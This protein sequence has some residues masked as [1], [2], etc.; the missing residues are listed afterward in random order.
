MKRRILLLIGL[1]LPV[2]ALKAQTLD[3][4][5]GYTARPL[6]TVGGEV[7]L[8]TL[9]TDVAGNIYYLSHG[10][11]GGALDTQLLRRNRDAGG[12]YSSETLIFSYG[13]NQSLFG[14][15][16]KVDNANS[17]IYFADSSP[18]ASNIRAIGTDLSNPRIITAL[19]GT[20]DIALSPLGL[21]VSA[22]NAG[23][24][25]AAN[26]VYKLNVG[27]GALDLIVDVAGDYSG[28]IEL[29]LAGNLIYG[30]TAF[31]SI[32]G[33]LYTFS[34]VQIAGAIGASSLTL[35]DGGVLADTQSNNYL[36]FRDPASL[37][38]AQTDA[39]TFENTINLFPSAG[40]TGDRIGSVSGGFFTGLDSW[41]SR[42]FV[43]VSDFGSPIANTTVYEIVPEPSAF[44]ITALGFLLVSLRRTARQRA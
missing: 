26:K 12:T 23:L 8:D 25:Q 10:N 2:F 4:A 33:D 20:Y 1:A 9:A 37:A 11:F 31:G 32:Q 44:G 41:D 42:L 35:G 17:T 6:F 27:T 29:D 34:Q 19:E 5:P 7:S 40:G 14:S 30:A 24:G 13:G 18:G 15:V 22:N 3:V 39:Q 21:F 38:Q 16:V 43:A 36:A 28:P